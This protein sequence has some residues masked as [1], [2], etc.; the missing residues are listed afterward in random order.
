MATGFNYGGTERLLCGIPGG[1]SSTPTIAVTGAAVGVGTTTVWPPGSFKPNVF[2]GALGH[3]GPAYNDLTFS[4]QVPINNIHFSVEWWYRGYWGSAAPNSD[5]QTGW[6]LVRPVLNAG[7]YT[8]WGARTTATSGQRPRPAYRSVPWGGIVG[9]DCAGAPDVYPMGW[10]HYVANYDRT[11]NVTAYNNAL[12]GWAFSNNGPLDA[13]D[14]D[15]LH[16]TIGHDIIVNTAVDATPDDW[17]FVQVYG[18]FGPFAIHNRLLTVAEMQ[19]STLNRRVNNLGAATTLV[20]YDWTNPQGVTGWD[21]DGDNTP[22]GTYYHPN[23]RGVPWAAPTGTTVVERDLSGNGRDYPMRVAA[24][25]SPTAL[26]NV[27]YGVDPFFLG[28]G[29]V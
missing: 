28:G 7:R 2:L 4:V 3:F 5:A 16:L 17:N 10:S 14:M 22:E 29:G 19:Q 8:D 12:T 21:S 20:N 27:A 15:N 11:G 1:G 23:L 9:V 6:W 18:T 13:T 26:S 24:G 25:Y